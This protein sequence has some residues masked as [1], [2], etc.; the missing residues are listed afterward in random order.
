MVS[1]DRRTASGAVFPTLE[2]AIQSAFQ[3]W[4][5]SLVLYSLRDDHDLQ[6]FNQTMRKGPGTFQV[7][8][9]TRGAAPGSLQ[10]QARLHG[11]TISIS[12]LASGSKVFDTNVGKDA[13]YDSVGRVVAKA[14]GV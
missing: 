5:L 4:C 13:S 7:D 8:L 1:Y 12:I 11:E 9:A 2:E 10:L 3:G 6:V 14:L